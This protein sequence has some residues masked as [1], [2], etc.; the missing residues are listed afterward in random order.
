M[1]KLIT[2]ISALFITVLTVGTSSAYAYSDDTFLDLKMQSANGIYTVMTDIE[3]DKHTYDGALN[4]KKIETSDIADKIASYKVYSNNEEIVN[5]QLHDIIPISDVN[6]YSTDVQPATN[7][8]YSVKFTLSQEDNTEA[9]LT[10][11]SDTNLADVQEAL[12]SAKLENSEFTMESL[13]FID[14]EKTNMPNDGDDELCWAA[15]SSNIFHYTGWGEQAGFNSPDALLDLFRDNF[16]DA[17]GATNFATEWFFNGRYMM[18]T[19]DNWSHVKNY[20][21]SGA[22]LTSYSSWSIVENVSVFNDHKNITKS[23]TAL[24]DGYGVAVV[25]DWINDSGVVNGSHAITLWGYICDN[26][27]YDNDSEHYTALI[28]SNSDSD[29]VSDSNRRKAPN[30]LNVLNMTPYKKFGYDSWS[31]DGYGGVISDFTNIKA[32]SDD[33]EYEKDGDATLDKFTAADFVIENI[34]VSNDELDENV[35]KHNFSLSDTVYINPIILNYG[36]NFNGKLSYNITV[37]DK[38]NGNIILNQDYTFEDEINS[39]MYGD[40]K[41]NTSV[42]LEAA[43][44]YTVTVSVNTGKSVSEAYY[45]NNTQKYDFKVLDTGYDLS[46]I[47]VN[48]VIGEFTD[49]IATTEITYDG[50]DELYL[51]QNTKYTLL[52]SYFDDD[53]WSSW[54]LSNTGDEEPVG[55]VSLYNTDNFPNQCFIYNIGEKVKF[56]LIIE[57]KD[58]VI[59]NIYS[60]ELELRYKDLEIVDTGTTKEFTPLGQGE[61]TLKN[62]ENISFKVRDLSTHDFGTLTCDVTVK[63]VNTN[64]EESVDLFE[65]KNI[66]VD[67]NSES[68]TISFDSWNTNKELS[69]TYRIYAS[70]DSGYGDVGAELGVLKVEE[71]PSCIVTTDQDVIDEYDGMTSLG[72]AVNNCKDGDEVTFANDISIINISQP[73]YITKSV[74]INGKDNG[75]SLSLGVMLYSGNKVQILNVKDTGNLNLKNISFFYGTSVEYGGALEVDGGTATLEN[76][77]ISNCT[78]GVSGGGVYAHNG[79]TLTLKDCL[80]KDNSSGYGGAVG[81]GKNSAVNMLN[82]TI[83]KNSSNSGAVHNNGGTFTAVYTTLLD[84]TTLS[85][86]G[87]NI[88]SISNSDT[89]LVGCIAVDDNNV[90]LS[91]DMRV[92]GSYIGKVDDKVVADD[93]E[94]GSQTQMF[95]TYNDETQ[96]L[97]DGNYRLINYLPYLT[98]KAENGVNVSVDNDKIVYWRLDAQKKNIDILSPFTTEEYQYDAFGNKHNGFYGSYAITYENVEFVTAGNGVQVYTPKKQ[99]VVFI[100]AHYGNDGTLIKTDINTFSLNS[101][102]NSFSVNSN[103]P[104]GTEDTKFMMWDSLDTMRPIA[105]SIDI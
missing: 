33:V 10:G 23:I 11:L 96:W 59:M 24:E 20:G 78:S 94:I 58:E 70:I 47:K 40:I 37:T 62:N 102:M 44:E 14:A 13:D 48:A 31:F 16:T 67:Y 34:Y 68:D 29:I 28:I 84:N 27:F 32:Y 101:G 6:L 89:Y 36:M 46:N 103:I 82:C 55:S 21:E 75:N 65:M 22:Y 35:K 98:C 2:T 86:G 38:S 50:L 105:E 7:G 17:G 53:K 54:T 85:E 56:R 3:G 91:G 30:K 45:Y 95:K 71:V 64:T 1:N 26:D 4:A 52:E 39:Y 57:N 18:Q 66:K 79:G 41:Q 90:S 99:E 81:V 72:E 8:Y 5:V 77:R 42:K 73:I 97:R 92:Y 69:G 100:A 19:N 80:F 49:G 93:C 12:I 76:C 43:G 74:T 51:P 104:E 88:N 61:N 9:F 15:A 25:L 63:A 83:F 60:D 87:S